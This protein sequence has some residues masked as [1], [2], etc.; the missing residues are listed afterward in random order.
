MG[1][2]SR[3]EVLLT[4]LG[5]VAAGGAAA[6]CRE[7]SFHYDHILGTSFDVL[8]ST[9]APS[10]IAA[11]KVLV[12]DEIER[13]RRVFSPFEPDSELSRLNRAD[14]AFPASPDLIAVLRYYETWQR[15]SGGTC[16]PQ[17]GGLARV[18]AEA[19]R[20]GTRPDA[21]TLARLAGKSSGPGWHI[22]ESRGTVTRFSSSSLNLNSVA[23]GYI[24][25]AAAEVVRRSLPSIEGFLINLGGDLC[26]WGDPT[27]RGWL[28][29]VQDPFRPEENATPLTAIRLCDAAV[30]TSGGYQRFVTIGGRRHSHIIDPRTGFPAD[31]VAAAT[32]VA[33]D[34]VTANVLATTL[35]VL[36]PDAGLRLVAATPGAECLVI[37]ADGRAFRSPG[38]AA[39]E[40][41]ADPPKEP[42]AEKK[43][44]KA[45]PWP[46]D[47]QVSIA[48]ELPRP[49]GRF[50]RPYVAVWIEDAG[51]KP[52]R[53]LTVW[54]DVGRWQRELSTWWKLA[55]DDADLIK[56]VTR[57]TRTP[58]KYEVVWDGRDDKGKALPQGMYAV[59][60]EVHREHG[61]HLTQTGKIECAA[62]AAT[63]KLE[64]NAEAEETVVEYAK[65]EK[66]K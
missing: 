14:G 29:G 54:G 7:F 4:G 10:A 32:V 51:G 36:G 28:V 22:D 58:G 12:L 37:D 42:P 57:A 5:A 23:K 66:K 27:G 21:T 30:A 18:W 33:A 52:V 65:K 9:G 11:A 63:A 56:A 64:K 50:R 45:E 60:V 19:G 8:V 25:R 17:L 49:M 6:P 59:K 48:I 39:L 15:R 44:K 34:A 43:E 40:C 26:G 31:G 1:G 2:P 13:L 38:F 62:T 53:T 20:L 47:Y 61:K 41:Y 35:C 24:I 16:N 55:K 3:R 46:A